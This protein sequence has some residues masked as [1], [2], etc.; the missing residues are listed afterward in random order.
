MEGR[1]KLPTFLSIT[2]L[3]V[4]VLSIGAY[5]APSV[6]IES[7]EHILLVELKRPEELSNFD[8]RYEVIERYDDHVLLRA[9]E[10]F[11][12]RMKEQ[13]LRVNMSPHRNRL[14]VGG[15]MFDYGE[16]EPDIPGELRV[17]DYRPG[18]RG[19]YIVH[20]LGPTAQSWRST[21]ERMGVQVLNFMHNYA[22]RVR[23]TPEL[24]KEV[25]DLHFV[26]RVSIYHPYFK[27]QPCIE[28]GKVNIGFI[29]D[30][31]V[32]SLTDFMGNVRLVSFRV[33][34]D[35]GYLF[36]V[37][38]PST[39]LLH[40]LARMNDV[41]FIS[42]YIEPELHCEMQSQIIGG[43][44]W[45]FDDEDSDPDT[46]YRKHGDYGS[47]I[48]Q[49]GYNGSGVV[50]GI[51]GQGLGG[52][53]TDSQHV[54][55]QDRV[56]GGYP[57]EDWGGDD[58]T[59]STPMA[60]CA[61]GNTYGGT[62]QTVYND[63][64]AG[65][66]SAPSSEL[67]AVKMF[68]EFG[69]PLLD[70][71]ES[72][73]VAKVHGDASVHS[74]SWG[75]FTEGSYDSNANEMDKAVRDYN[76]TVTVSAGNGGPDHTTIESPAV[77]KNVI[78][79]GA[80]HNYNPSEGVNNP[81]NVADFSSRG[82]TQDNRVKP[83]VVA[84]GEVIYSLHNDDSYM[85]I[86][87][88]SLSSPAVAGTAAVI[89]QWYVYNH[90]SHPSP[91]IVK[92]LLINMANQL[93]GNTEGPVPNRDEGWGMVDI[94][95]LE[96]P[97]DNPVPFYLS[98][99]E[100]IFN[101]SGQ[102]N[103]HTLVVDR[104]DEPLKISL[105]WTDKEAPGGTGDGRTLINDLN[106][107]VETPGGEIIRGN[108]FDLS[109]DGQSDDGFTYPDAQVMGDF[110]YSGDGWDD[111]NNV[112]NVYLH[113]DYVELG[114]Y[115]VRVLAENIADDAVGI[116]ENSQDYALVAYNAMDGTQDTF[117]ISLYAGGD[118]DGWNFVSFNLGPLDVTLESILENETHGISGSYDRLMYYDAE[119]DGWL[120]YVPGRADHFN[121][122]EAWNHRMGMWIRMSATD[123]L[124]VEGYVP[125][126]TDIT[127]Y[128]GW[129]MVG[130]PSSTSGNHGLPAEVTI[131]GYFD[132]TA[133]Y[134]LAYDHNSEAF[135]FEPGKGYWL[136]NSADE[137]VVWTVEY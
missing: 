74:N 12:K 42:Q 100:H 33:S 19:Q 99:Q 95:K 111:T 48:N 118:A 68:D 41:L 106:L 108:A 121:T 46:A 31:G 27:L 91:A 131:V 79:V 130:L 80:T 105:V 4:A 14:Y 51:A 132:A 43:G 104:L 40:D 49:I 22:Y 134:N 115:T 11:V 32:D 56:I 102:V 114:L 10:E 129:N 3:I 20:M 107:E 86:S 6:E 101:G 18:E 37:Y 45:F 24:A 89:I 25:S 72:V 123:T 113:P 39:D 50:I 62:G 1:T 85:Y 98:D 9:D 109:G 59:D 65:Q 66:G 34:N 124:T 127:L 69:F 29:P 96:R 7:E 70:P 116:G 63:Y 84:P 61:A 54:D 30:A 103:E 47:Y 38:V 16:G 76:M 57:P 58:F 75:L 94:S 128:S 73:E 137:A 55:L 26:E 60:G 67:F 120:T 92:G 23:M 87:G 110:D 81:E 133:E 93:D 77:G 83:D 44:L 88:T 35:G 5:T 8:G 135:V 78:A 64:Y 82:W 117:D 112:E 36:R 28:P 71:Y 52:G 2:F 122:L 53:T 97:L 17:D 125:T 13:G 90:N 21:L 119:T 136:Y 15:E 126:S